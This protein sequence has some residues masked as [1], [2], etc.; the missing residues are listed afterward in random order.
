[1]SDT[2]VIDDDDRYSRLRLIAWW[3]QEKLG[4]VEGARRRRRGARQRGAEES[5]AARRRHGYVVDFDKI[6][7]SNLTRSRA[8]S[9]RDCGRSKAEVAAETLREINPRCTVRP[10]HANVI[11]DVGLGLFRDVDVVIG[12]LDNREARLWVNRQCWKVE[13]A[14]DRR[15]HSGDQRRGEGVHAAG[16]RRATNAP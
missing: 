15:R 12:C 14:L 5:R 6:E 16:E 7:E 3:D 2:L 8:V 9:P 11:T 1:M 10:M 13:H 4:A